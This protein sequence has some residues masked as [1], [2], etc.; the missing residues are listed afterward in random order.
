[1]KK[2]V[3]L[4]L[5]GNIV[6]Q[7]HRDGVL[8]RRTLLARIAKEIRQSVRQNP[9]LQLIII[10][11][12]GAAGHQ[13][14]KKYHLEKGTSN[15]PQKIKG[16]LLIREANQKLNL[17]VSQIF[18]NSGVYVVPIH[19]QSIIIQKDGKIASCSYAAIESTINAQF[20]P[21]LYGEMV[22]DTTLG[23]SICSGD[24]IAIHLA[25]HF[26]AEKILFASD[27]DGI[28][29]KDPHMHKN[30]KIIRSTSLQNL[31]SNKDVE[32]SGSHHVDVT[33]GMRNKIVSITKNGISKTLKEVVVFNGLKNNAFTKAIAGKTEG[34]TI[35]IR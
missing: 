13:T 1:M 31:L 4:K 18:T 25:K 24:I 22:F 15:N 21:I 5:G 9:G 17:A 7:K 26:G 6:T 34:T 23:M 8:V 14:A 29:D 16:A 27:V 28:Y 32:L 10:H 2:T 20:I 12:A 3:I 35:T 30:A 19:T 11:G 33:G